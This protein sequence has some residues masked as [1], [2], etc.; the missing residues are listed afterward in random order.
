MIDT[1]L[2][3][4]V[5][6]VLYLLHTTITSRRLLRNASLSI[7]I[8]NSTAYHWWIWVVVG[9]IKPLLKCTQWVVFGKHGSWYKYESVQSVGRFNLVMSFDIVCT[10]SPCLSG[11]VHPTKYTPINTHTHK[12]ITTIL[13]TSRFARS[14]LIHPPPV[15]CQVQSDQFTLDIVHPSVIIICIS[16]VDW[17]PTLCVL[18]LELN[19]WLALAQFLIR[20][21]RGRNNVH[22]LELYAVLLLITDG[23]RASSSWK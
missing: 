7:Y 1:L 2:S 10:N 6:L 4:N 3:L 19:Y 23:T 18:I 17:T 21:N 9:P 8:H 14:T 15:F 22:P 13:H 12:Y 16:T 20:A 11:L 5:K